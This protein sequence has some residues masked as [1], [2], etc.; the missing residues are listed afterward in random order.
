[1]A[2]SS[3][4]EIKNLELHSVSGN[5]ND[6]FVGMKHDGNEIHIYHPEC[7]PIKNGTDSTKSD[8]LALLKTISLAKTSSQKRS[9]AFNTQNDG[10]DFALLSYL[11]L[12]NDYLVNG[13]YVNRDKVFKVNQHGKINWKRTLQ[14]KPFFT[15]QNIYF[16]SVIVEKKDNLENIL[17]EAHKICIKKSI[18]YI[19]WLFDLDS[20]SILVPRLTDGLKMLY[21]NAIQ[22]ELKNTYLDY[23][24]ILLKHMNNVLNGLDERSNNKEFVYGVDSYHYIFE[25]M[26]DLIFGN[27]DQI[28]E[29]YPSA[30][31][32]IVENKNE[33]YEKD[34]SKLR[35]DTIILKSDGNENY[36]A[37]IIDSKFYR[38]GYTGNAEDLPETTSIQKQITYGEYI[39]KN[40][41]YQITNAFSAF[42]LPYDKCQ[43]RFNSNDIIKYIGFAKSDW[44]DNNDSHELIHAFLIDLK[45]VI[46]EWNSYNNDVVENLVE[47]IKEN[48]NNAYKKS[49]IRSL[50]NRY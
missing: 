26:I 22:H 49:V 25:R 37:Y 31:W 10:G 20:D 12:I 33:Y 8:I 19:G 48:Q 30:K 7:Y 28:R 36:D 16:P 43:N 4:K 41:K 23:K 21:L 15:E 42:I 29:F 39:K 50:S 38:F 27:V 46:N 40:T 2:F 34:A 3:S 9:K 24:R 44:K 17:V 6:S 35:P 11:W 13:F 47:A 1:M 45:Y 5:A 14:T 18:D 32:Y